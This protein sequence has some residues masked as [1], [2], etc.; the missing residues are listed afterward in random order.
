LPLIDLSLPALRALSPVQWKDFQAVLDALIAADRHVDLLEWSLRRILRRVSPVQGPAARPELP[1]RGLEGLRDECAL[2]LSC[3]AR[4]G[5][6][7]TARAFEA[8]TR[9]LPLSNVS[10]RPT[11]AG[12]LERLDEALDA[13]AALA[14]L[15][16]R[17][18]LAACAAGVMVDERVTV[19][20]AELLRAVADA[21]GCPVPPDVVALAGRLDSPHDARATRGPL[22][23]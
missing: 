22:S 9:S 3:L 5:G 1:I 4:A 2:L 16:K 11:E 10:L 20:E 8:A 12:E 21:L 19:E 6:A 18:L 15:H 7:P 14:P 23:T 17:E 13:L